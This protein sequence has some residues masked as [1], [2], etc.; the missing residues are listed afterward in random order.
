MRNSTMKRGYDYVIVGAGASGSVIAARLSEDPACRV[1]LL[2]AGGRDWSPLY[3]IPMG[4]GKLRAARGGLWRHQTEPEPWLD[5]RSMALATGK[6]AGG[7]AAINGMVYLRAPDADYDRWQSATGGQWNAE[8]LR[9]LFVRMEDPLSGTLAPRQLTGE[10]PL[11]RAFVQAC[12]QSGIPA[13]ELLDGLEGEGAGL[14]RFNIRNGRRYSTPQAYLKP[15]RARANLDVDTGSTVLRVDVANGRARGVQVLRRGVTAT[16]AAQREVIVA[17]GALKSPQ[18][19]MLSGIGPANILRE[20]GIAVVADLKGVGANLQNH[21]DIA[22]RYACLEPVTL[23]SLLR[24]ERILPAMLQAW[25]FGT[26]PAARFPGEACVL[27]KTTPDEPLPDIKAHLVAGLGIRGI[28]WPWTQPVDALLDREGFSCRI[29]LLRP[30]SRGRVSLRSADPHAPPAVQFGYLS[31]P[32]EMARLV[33]GVRRMRSVFAAPAFDGLRGE[34]IEPGAAAIDDSAL[35]AWIRARADMQCHPVGTCAMGSSDTAVVDSA[36]RVHE[37]DGLRVADASVMPTIIGGGAFA[38][39]VVI[40]E[41]AA[42][43]LRAQAGA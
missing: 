25:L 23:H 38:A 18:L 1:L 8:A 5:G 3:R 2:E 22:L 10:H 24:A 13:R 35:G 36:L 17:A 39:T 19:L 9:H 4:V 41:K 11:D 30:Q 29:M 27:I 14:L 33:A 7:S 12:A 20:H 28:R 15:A 40:A 32:A 26:G 16:I 37:V 42:E 43:I 34:E 31:Q 6:V 21:V